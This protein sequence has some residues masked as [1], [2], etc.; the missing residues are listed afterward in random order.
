MVIGCIFTP[1]CTRSKSFNKTGLM[2]IK[3][4]I[5]MRYSVNCWNPKKIMINLYC[6][7]VM[8]EVKVEVCFNVCCF[9]EIDLFYRQS[10]NLCV[11]VCVM[12]LIFYQPDYLTPLLV[13]TGTFQSSHLD[14]HAI[15]KRCRKCCVSFKFCFL[16]LVV[17]W[18]KHWKLQKIN[19]RLHIINSF[20]LSN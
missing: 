13:W 15:T 3:L 7:F 4:Y 1:R 11:Y 6:L 14:N 10:C 20:W 16:N 9:L 18:S 8:Q 12:H 5:P 19:V 17:C 2:N